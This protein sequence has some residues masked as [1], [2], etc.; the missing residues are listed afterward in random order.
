MIWIG[1]QILDIC[2]PNETR[3]EPNEGVY[4]SVMSACESGAQWKRAILLLYNR[5]KENDASADLYSATL[6]ACAKAGQWEQ[7]LFL[8]DRMEEERTD[9]PDAKSYNAA[10]SACDLGLRTRAGSF[11][12]YAEEEYRH[13]LIV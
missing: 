3:I 7:V 11:R 1:L 10:L 12:H 13:G 5:K 8:F 2:Q 4:T 9:P 6:S